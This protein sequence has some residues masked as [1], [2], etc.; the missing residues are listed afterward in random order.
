[1]PAKSSDGDILGKRLV[2]DFT[3]R[4]NDFLS[5]FEREA[6]DNVTPN[7]RYL[8]AVRAIDDSKSSLVEFLDDSCHGLPPTRTFVQ[9]PAWN[10]FEQASSLFRCPSC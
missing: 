10:Q 6:G 9:H 2:F 8:G 4:E 3:D 1:V 5:R 7:E